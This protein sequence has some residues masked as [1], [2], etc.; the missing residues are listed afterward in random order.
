MPQFT[1]KPP[2]KPQGPGSKEEKPAG[3]PE[4][5]SRRSLE[6]KLQDR[7]PM[8]F[9]RLRQSARFAA[10]GEALYYIGLW[11]EYTVLRAG[12]GLR[13]WAR[14]GIRR[15]ARLIGRGW[16][17]LARVIG[18]TFEEITGPIVYFHQGWQSTSALV[19]WTYKSKGFMGAARLLFKRLNLGASRFRHLTRR[20]GVYLLPLSAFAVFVF[21][22]QTVVHYNYI[23]AVYVN[24]QIVGYVESENVFD[25][26]KE[27][28]Q[29]RVE[30]AN[31]ATGDASRQLEI[32]P[33]FVLAVQGEVLDEN[34]MA[35]AILTAASDEIQEATALYVDGD[36]AAITTDGEDLREDLEAIK[37][38]YEDPN[39]PNQRVE[40]T[41]DVEVVDG[42]YFTDSISDYDEVYDKITG[43]EQAEVL[44]Q[45]QEGDTPWSIALS[46]D[47][48]IDELY[49][50]N[51]QMTE[52]G[53]NMYVGDELVIGQER[54]YLP[55][56]VIYTET[57]Q[58]EV[59]YETI[60]TE[61]DE[62]DWGTT[63]T[64]TQG[65]NGLKEVVADVTY[66]NGVEIG[67]EILQETMLQE[68]VNEE[69]VK[70][71]RLKDGSV[72]A[73]ATGTIMWPVPNYRYVSRW[74]SSS[75]KG[76]DICAAYGTA[77][78]A[79]DSGVVTAS[80]YNAAG[81]GYGYSIIINHGNGMTTLYAHCAELYVS[82]GTYVSQGQVIG[83]VG[84]TGQ[85]TGNHCHFEIRIN[86]A[87]TSA[88]NYFPGM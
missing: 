72:A 49:A 33:T 7:F 10:L 43:L 37:E 67:R 8:L 6:D 86:G 40:F 13:Y 16:R 17:R 51:P 34:A 52:T 9:H 79:A 59:P 77:I 41:K 23:L 15:A 36:L 44:Y 32:K 35:D 76:A 69:V 48:T 42:I 45:V 3:M 61:S 85:S 21:T 46:H 83:A 78:L 73:T 29:Q 18:H 66:E 87:L 64:I 28:V 50:M 80:G 84:S 11:S 31:I 65:S 63:K 47:L 74:M 71:T 24:D 57:Y 2:G 70:G 27:D 19:H 54:Q 62:Y 4:T 81:S 30:S 5:K 60:T 39:D 88:R 68:V 53:Y 82:A 26:A 22:V 58:V 14:T 75:H 12:R 55:V 25:Q 1:Q 38:P 20:A 56:K